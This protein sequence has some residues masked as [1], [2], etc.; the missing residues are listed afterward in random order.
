MMDLPDNFFKGY[1]CRELN[2][3]NNASFAIPDPIWK[4]IRRGWSREQDKRPWISEVV[5]AVG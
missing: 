4:L 3:N 5:K 1:H 2:V